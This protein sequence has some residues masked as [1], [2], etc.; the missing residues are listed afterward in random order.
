MNENVNSSEI[1]KVSIKIPPFWPEKPEIWFFQVEAQF[2]INHISAEDTKFNYLIS[3]LEPRIVENI[4]DIITTNDDNKY[5]SA[6]NRLL[7]I[8]KE[9]ESNRLRK[10]IAGIE[11]GD[12]KPS[13]L[14]QKLKALAGNDL[15]EKV[16]KTI[17]IDKLPQQIR[18]VIIVS[19]ESIDKLSL[20]ADKISDIN[21]KH[22]LFAADN[23]DSSKPSIDALLSKI[24]QLENQV[25]QLSMDNR[26][27]D[28]SRNRNNPANFRRRSNSRNGFKPNG[29]ICYYHLKFKE[30][31]I[32][33]KC[34]PPCEWNNSGN[35]NQQQK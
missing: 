25:S 35:E 18:N 32:P 20:M 29:K 31:C 16:L 2:K 12:L 28:R 26:S 34:R 8:F 6:K 3:Q 4:W 7:D 24:S 33:S 23:R 13:Q 11:L 30:R 17:W 10:L 15:S 5:T 1:G 27:R 9:S 14:L 21:P 22:E 19:E